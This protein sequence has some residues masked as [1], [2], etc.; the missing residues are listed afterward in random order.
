MDADAALYYIFIVV[1]ICLVMAGPF[2]QRHY[3]FAADGGGPT[4][5]VDVLPDLLPFLVFVQNVL[6]G[7]A[8]RYHGWFAVSWSLAIE[9]WFYFALAIV[10]FL[11]PQKVKGD[12]RTWYWAGLGLIAAVVLARVLVVIVWNSSGQLPYD[13]SFRRAML[14]RADA[15]AYGGA[16]YVCGRGLGGSKLLRFRLSIAVIGLGVILTSWM[17]RHNAPEGVWTKVLLPSLVPF[18]AALLLPFC[19]AIKFDAWP[20]LGGILVFLSTRTYSIYLA[21]IPLQ[22]FF[23][24]VVHPSHIAYA[25]FLVVLCVVVNF[26]YV[27]VERPIMTLRPMAVHLSPPAA[28][29]EAPL[30]WRGRCRGCGQGN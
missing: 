11:L 4:R 15:F 26:L 10:L 19:G 14:L 6:D 29:K 1:N 27:Y 12:V 2:I 3:Q 7:G 21:H 13:N 20:A 9:E 25:T 22:Y 24:S 23:F 5:G 18:G 17:M 28:V 8:I 30:T 16:I